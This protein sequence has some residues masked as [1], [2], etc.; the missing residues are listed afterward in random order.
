ME[1]LIKQAFLHVDVIGPHVQ[2]GHYD[3]IGPNGEII[4]PQVWEKVIEPDW[5]ITM[6][7]WPMDRP[8][9]PQGAMGRG[10]AGP[11]HMGARF[12]APQGFGQMGRRPSGGAQQQPPPPPN[13]HPGMAGMGGM[14][15]FRP[16]GVGARPPGGPPVVVQ[17]NKPD[18]KKSKQKIQSGVLGWIG[19]G[20]AK[21]SKSKRTRR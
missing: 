21:S 6:H 14:G 7:M 17:V 13:H 1:E 5:A 9:M 15:N 2:A 3:L 10:Q 12:G 16:N 4:L 19:G 18:G 11:M 20:A 8:A